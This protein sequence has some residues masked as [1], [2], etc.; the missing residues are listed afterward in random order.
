MV[1]NQTDFNGVKVLQVCVCVNVIQL[2]VRWGHQSSCRA[3]VEVQY[4]ML[5]LQSVP[6]CVPYSRIAIR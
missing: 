6:P 1:G 2:C 5:N 4:R 3:I